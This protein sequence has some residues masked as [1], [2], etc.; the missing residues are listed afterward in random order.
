MAQPFRLVI[1][2]PTTGRAASRE[3]SWSADDH[4]ILSVECELKKEKQRISFLTARISD[5]DRKIF[6]ELPDPAY[7]DVPV[8]FYMGKPGN[9]DAPA[10]LVF[11]GKLTRMDTGWPDNKSLTVAAHDYSIE[12]RRKKRIKRFTN[13][14]SAE[15]A[16]KVADEYGLELEQDT[17]ILGGLVRRVSVVAL[18][19][20]QSDWDAMTAALATDGI[21]VYADK[22]R[23]IK[24]RK[25][26]SVQYGTTITPDV[27]LFR[28]EGSIEHI[29]GPGK[30]GD[31]Q[32][33]Q[34][35]LENAGT[36]KAL[37]DARPAGSA[38]LT[39][40][41]VQ[42]EI[43]EQRATKREGR[44]PVH[45]VGSSNGAHSEDGQGVKWS[46][47]VD[48]LKKRKDSLT[49]VSPPLHDISLRNLVKLSGWGPKLDGLW[50]PETIH[51]VLVPADGFSSTTIKAQRSTGKQAA[52]EANTTFVPFQ[53]STTG[54]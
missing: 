1:N 54:V 27:P 16:K 30:G 46:P 22:H 29:R 37:I 48:L 20:A 14:T 2:A 44:N 32:T 36:I 18:A 10:T 38:P 28:L 25:A 23:K 9:P 12:M 51:H 43:R 11:A 15:F 17:N 50:E 42:A 31:I 8:S 5:P 13:L 49:I 41:Q 45:G 47:Q 19:P 24:L 52:S 3:W 26:A 53:T 33:S 40:A 35:A 7:A 21:E 6:N 4:R 34:V 39:V